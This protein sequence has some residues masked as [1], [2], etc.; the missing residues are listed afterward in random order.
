LR[1]LSLG[2]RAYDLHEL[3]V[4][5]VAERAGLYEQQG[6]EVELVDLRGGELPHEAT[7]AC[8]AALFAA[9]DGAPV[10]IV[11]VASTAPLFWLYG[12]GPQ[13]SCG[14]IATYP[15]SAPP[16]RFL[17]LALRGDASFIAARNDLERLSLMRAG[18]ADCALLSSA[19]PPSRVGDL[20]QLLCVGDEIRVP[21]T[22]LATSAGNEQAVRPL[23]AAHR[24]A[25]GLLRS[26][27]ALARASARDAFGFDD[28]E[29]EWAVGV[30]HR[31]F[32]ADGRIPAGYVDAA[33][34]TVGA[35]TSPYA[36]CAVAPL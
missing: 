26:D 6:V 17:E 30:A 18:K 16:A 21:S 1:A 32:S 27:P 33:L 35:S 25:L 15:L 31:Y 34:R 4:H 13:A 20:E 23:V 9:L 19:T 11:L 12:G 14:R 29:S 28:Q 7:V 5:F 24:R 8:G 10:R 2:F 22:G 36:A 3:L